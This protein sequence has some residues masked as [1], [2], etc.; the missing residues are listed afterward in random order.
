MPAYSRAAGPMSEKKRTNIRKDEGRRDPCLAGGTSWKTGLEQTVK[1][2]RGE[3][4]NQNK[5]KS[6]SET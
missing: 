6:A 4:E 2:R 5:R 3:G 1:L